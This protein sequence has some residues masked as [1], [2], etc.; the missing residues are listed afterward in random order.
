MLIKTKDDTDYTDTVKRTFYLIKED[1]G[2]TARL[3]NIWTLLLR[4]L[5]LDEFEILTPELYNNDSFLSFLID[6]QQDWMEGK[7][8]NFNEIY[9]ALLTVGDFT[10][11]E[12]FLMEKAGIEEILW[13]IFIEICDPEKIL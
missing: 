10:Q 3:S 11:K 7:E 5:G 9:E 8:V 2:Y 13:G 12:K 4:P 1:F 6:K